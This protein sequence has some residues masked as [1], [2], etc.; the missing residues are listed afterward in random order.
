MPPFFYIGIARAS[1]SMAAWAI[2]VSVLLTVSG[3]QRVEVPKL[4]RVHGRSGQCIKDLGQC[5]SCVVSF[6][7]YHTARYRA[8]LLIQEHKGICGKFTVT[9]T[10]RSE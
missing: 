5:H 10:L 7:T 2:W 4:S 8:C 6:F 1:P 3:L 9:I